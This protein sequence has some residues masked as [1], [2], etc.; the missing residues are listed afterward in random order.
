MDR[1]DIITF[2]KRHRI[3]NYSIRP[4]GV[5]DVD[6]DVVMFVETL[7][8]GGIKFGNVSG[9]FFVNWS[10]LSS[11]VGFPTFVGNTLSADY[12]HLDNSDENFS[13][14]YQCDCKEMKFTHAFMEG[15]RRY[16]V[17]RMRIDNINDILK[18]E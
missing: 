3:A 1:D 8:L 17:K 16:Q 4:D 7:N 12:C 5:I 10:N 13:I 15:Y 11:M 6:G 18:N 14:I 2:C 9:D